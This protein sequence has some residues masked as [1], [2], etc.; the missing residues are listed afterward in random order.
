V[1]LAGEWRFCEKQGVRKQSASSSHRSTFRHIDAQKHIQPAALFVHPPGATFSPVRPEN[2]FAL[3][4]EGK[5]QA[6][7]V[8]K[9][10]APNGM[11]HLWDT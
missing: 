7:V 8:E 4:L 3:L 11:R 5:K 1:P 6:P 2:I 10:N 9:K